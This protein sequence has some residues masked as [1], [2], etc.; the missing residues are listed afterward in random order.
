MG[1]ELL[2]QPPK[3][4][5]LNRSDYSLSPHLKKL[6]AERDLAPAKKTSINSIIL[7]ERGKKNGETLD[8]VYEAQGE[9]HWEMKRILL[10][11]NLLFIQKVTKIH[12]F[13]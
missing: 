13:N 5:D 1:Y 4:P 6:L 7:F 12:F 11:I 2:P 3:S 8:K 9:L 10:K